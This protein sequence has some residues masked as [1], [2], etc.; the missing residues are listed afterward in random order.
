[1]VLV[2]V[3]LFWVMNGRP[4]EGQLAMIVSGTSSAAI[5]TA[6]AAFG[7]IQPLPDPTDTDGFLGPPL[8]ACRYDGDLW[9]LPFN[10]DAGLLF[11]NWD[12]V[13]AHLDDD[14]ERYS[15]AERSWP[16]LT[17]LVE[18]VL[19]DAPAGTYG[20][21][22]QH[23]N[24]EG[25]T[26]KALE[27]PEQGSDPMVTGGWR[28]PEVVSCVIGLS[29]TPISTRRVRPAMT[30][31]RRHCQPRG[32]ARARRQRPR[33]PEP[34]DLE[35][36]SPPRKAQELIEFLTNDDNQKSCSAKAGYP[37]PVRARTRTCSIGAR[38]RRCSGRLSA[39]LAAGSA[40]QRWRGS[41]PRRRTTPGSAKPSAMP[42]PERSA[43]ATYLQ[44]WTTG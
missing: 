18:R 23:R 44:T 8:E 13:G 43:P 41:A 36:L 25:L 35:P 21:A 26:V 15:S 9:A 3:W 34:R 40:R 30:T 5:S 28:D 19:R 14:D 12:L 22:G 37:R 2:V 32:L 29:P 27:W 7:Y 38:T 1:V 17:D 20:Y 11:V 6:F 4:T 24:Y 39:S 42:C 10:T 31:V 33:R 16:E